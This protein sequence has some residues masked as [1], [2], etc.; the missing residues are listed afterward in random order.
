MCERALD[1]HADGLENVLTDDV[2]VDRWEFAVPVHPRDVVSRS[3]R[4]LL[5]GR[6]SMRHGLSFRTSMST[7][8]FSVGAWSGR[9][10][11]MRA[12][13]SWPQCGQLYQA[14]I[15]ELSGVGATGC[16]HSGHDIRAV[17]ARAAMLR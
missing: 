10:L 16:P 3:H 4:V 2:G 7:N 6:G 5:R 11:R 14:T 12:D 8:R 17:T 9:P 13:H 15:H 1:A